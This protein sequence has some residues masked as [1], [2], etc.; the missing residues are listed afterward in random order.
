MSILQPFSA[1]QASYWLQ[2]SFDQGSL[3]VRTFYM[4][5]IWSLYPKFGRP[6]MEVRSSFDFQPN[7]RQ[8]KQR[9]HR[10]MCPL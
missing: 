8:N 10:M 4:V 3:K 2:L 6:S 9:A 7:K 5:A 1:F